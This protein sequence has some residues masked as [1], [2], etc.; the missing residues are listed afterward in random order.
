VTDGETVT[1]TQEE[2]RGSLA[3]RSNGTERLEAVIEQ[4]RTRYDFRTDLEMDDLCTLVREFFAGTKD[5]DLAR[6]LDISR[7]TVFRARMDLHLLRNPDLDAPFDLST[8]RDRLDGSETLADVAADVGVS[9]STIRRY[10]DAL[11]A[12]EESRAANDRY[13]DEFA[14]IL[15][16]AD[17]SA[18]LTGDINRD[19]LRDATED[20]EVN[21]DF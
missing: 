16:D 17:L 20:A 19:G 2:S 9:E 15:S 3:N 12:R 10:R 5:A 8:L 11:N 21:V 6:E 7:H 1:E 14:A 13:H 18:H 4:M